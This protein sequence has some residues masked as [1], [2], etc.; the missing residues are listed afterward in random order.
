MK[1]CSRSDV[2]IQ[3]L[4]ERVKQVTREAILAAGEAVFSE[5]GFSGA[6]VEEIAERAGV[7]VGTL[8]NYFEDRRAILD[9][10]LDASAH[11]LAARL[12]EGRLPASAGFARQLEQFLD[13][14]V[15]EVERG[16]R[17]YAVVLGEELEGGRSGLARKK[18]PLMLRVVYEAADRIVSE[19]V[20]A[21]GLR[22]ED[23][24]IYPALLV[25]MLRGLLMRQLC[26]DA[27]QP[28]RSYVGPLTRFF[29]DGAARRPA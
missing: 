10:V 22:P 24:P 2:G 25:G 9:A 29:L 23:A 18:G 17:L 12:A 16:V 1:Q 13:I 21:G 7:A 27:R 28:L 15:E 26:I 8:Y 11:K 4:R 5:R 3:P 19:A 6:R 20:R 14:A